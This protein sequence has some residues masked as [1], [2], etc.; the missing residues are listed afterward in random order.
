MKHCQKKL[1]IPI[2]GKTLHELLDLLLPLKGHYR[3]PIVSQRKRIR[4]GTMR[5]QVQSLALFSGLRSGI[6]V[7]YGVGLR[8]S[9]DPMLLWPWRRPMA[10]APIRPLA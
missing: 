8:R 10:T 4:L 6:A 5:L 7:S 2:H 1:K 9:S 3:V